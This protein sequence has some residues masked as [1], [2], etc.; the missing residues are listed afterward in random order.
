MG[1]QL[2]ARRVSPGEL[3]ELEGTPE[4]RRRQAFAE[5]RL[6]AGIS[7][8][9]PGLQS[10]W[11]HHDGNDTVVYMLAGRLTV[12]FGE[13][14]AVDAEAGDFLIIPAGLVHREIT[15]SGAP[16]E[17]V[18]RPHRRD[19]PPTVEVDGPAS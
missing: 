19:G 6:W 2:G 15:P 8:T 4:I 5:P 13:G 12:G 1:E 18:V 3:V 14:G 10:G 17:A 16:T 11:H 9:Q 7:T